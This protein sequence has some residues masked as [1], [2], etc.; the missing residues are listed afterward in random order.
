M[1]KQVFNG[2]KRSENRRRIVEGI[3]TLGGGKYRPFD[4]FRDWVETSAIAFSNAVDTSQ[5]KGREDRYMDI[6]GK[7]T[8]EELKKFAEMLALLVLDFSDGQEGV[9]FDDAL[10]DIFMSCEFGGVSRG[11][12]FTPFYIS[13]LMVRIAGGPI[14]EIVNNRGFVTVNEPTCG[15]GGMCIA[16]AEKVHGAGFNYQRCLHIT[17]QDIDPTCIHMAYIQLSILNIPA[18]LYLGDTLR[19]D[20]SSQWYTPAHVLGGWGRR[21]LKGPVVSV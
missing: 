4:V 14:P 10:G 18:V 1:K 12:F 6:V 7:Y 17:A 16:A 20:F 2:A 21:T 19:M 11:Q 9:N 15:S 8:K 13:R 3:R 5:R